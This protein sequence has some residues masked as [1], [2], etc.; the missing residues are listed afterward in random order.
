MKTYLFT[1]IIALLSF[2]CER[3]VVTINPPGETMET[4]IVVPG[5]PSR[6]NMTESRTETK[7]TTAPDGTTTE[8]TETIEKK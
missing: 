3:K 6:E 1:A 7:T 8:K 4:P 5:P 2:S